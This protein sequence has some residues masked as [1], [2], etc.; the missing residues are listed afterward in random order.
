MSL[1]FT[2]VV[3]APKFEFDLDAIDFGRVSY[4]FLNS[5]KA[6]LHNLSDIPIKYSLRYCMSS[7]RLAFLIVL[8]ST[9]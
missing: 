1:T 5:V 7:L 3:V 8:Q 9:A 4:G 2:G 6:V